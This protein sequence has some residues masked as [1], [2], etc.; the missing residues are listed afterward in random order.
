MMELQ[1]GKSGE[2][3]HESK[4]KLCFH[5]LDEMIRRFGAYQ[6]LGF[7]L[8]DVIYNNVYCSEPGDFNE[9]RYGDP[10]TPYY[11]L[12]EDL[13]LEVDELTQFNS[14]LEDRLGEK[15]AQVSK[16]TDE[17]KDANHL[18]LQFVELEHAL[19][20]K[21]SINKRLR[22]ANDTLISH[23]EDL[24]EQLLEASKSKYDSIAQETLKKTIQELAKANRNANILS[25]RL[26]ESLSDNRLLQNTI[27]T[28][29]AS[30]VETAK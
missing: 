2:S 13:R 20:Q 29:K 18:K 8:R 6:R 21:T 22:K 24:E 9:K 10:P 27:D 25:S 30:M 23:N 7:N 26:R 15:E 4:L 12:A 28:L 14:E 11:K 16:L 19:R 1:E 3:N 17:L 5:F